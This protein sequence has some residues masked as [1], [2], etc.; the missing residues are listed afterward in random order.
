VTEYTFYPIEYWKQGSPLKAGLVSVSFR[1]LDPQEIIELCVDCGLQGIEWGGDVHVPPGDLARASQVSE[2]TREAGLSVAAYGSYYFLGGDTK[3]SQFA[4]V[5]ET[6]I[7]LQ[8]PVIRIWAGQKA[9]SEC[10]EQ[11]WVEAVEDSRRVADMAAGEDI[12]IAYEYHQGT[13]TD[14]N[15]SAM[16]LLDSVN[17]PNVFTF[18]Q[19]PNGKETA[20]CLDG[21]QTVIDAGKLSS[22]HVFHWWP[23]YKERHLLQAGAERW[24]SYLQLAI[25]APGDRL[26]CLEF[27][28]DDD[29]ENTRRDAATLMQ[30]IREVSV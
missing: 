4:D 18:W 1:N 7:N 25:E 17:H 9:S 29:P 20:Y 3:G 27:S 19:P 15:E 30:L 22:L 14:T 2:M 24:L 26:A 16:K 12:K 10:T 8:A 23:G 11:D 13:L 28:K 21:L 6:A 5:L